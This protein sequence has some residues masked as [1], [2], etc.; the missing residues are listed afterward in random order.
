MNQK[1]KI[2]AVYFPPRITKEGIE[3][4]GGYEAIV[5][6][7]QEVECATPGSLLRHETANEAIYDIITANGWYERKCEIEIITL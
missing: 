3:I 6:N 4:P 1:P 5:L 2:R 7:V